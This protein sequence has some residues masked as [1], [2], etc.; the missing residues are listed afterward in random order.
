AFGGHL[1]FGSHTTTGIDGRL[2]FSAGWL[3]LVAEGTWIKP[4]SQGLHRKGAEGADVPAGTL[5]LSSL[6]LVGGPGTALPVPVRSPRA[7]PRM[8]RSRT[9]RLSST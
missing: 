1:A 8:V 6:L 9:R 2:V 7:R 5:V 3:E 4:A